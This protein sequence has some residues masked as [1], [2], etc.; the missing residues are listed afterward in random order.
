MMTDERL[1]EIEN[2]ASMCDDEYDYIK[3]RVVLELLA[4]IRRLRETLRRIANYK[5]ATDHEDDYDSLLMV[6]A[7]ALDEFEK[8][9]L[10][11]D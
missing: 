9:E 8:M 10:S 7:I 3:A 6:Q 5:K 4:E 1:R 11:H 2:D